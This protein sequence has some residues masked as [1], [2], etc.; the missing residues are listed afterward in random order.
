MDNPISWGILLIVA[1]CLA[2]WFAQKGYSELSRN[3]REN[4]DFF[5]EI[6]HGY[7]RK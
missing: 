1:I 5:W 7:R 3:E 2:V 4:D 6:E